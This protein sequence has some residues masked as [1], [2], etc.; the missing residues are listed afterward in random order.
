MA[1]KNKATSRPRPGEVPVYNSAAEI[2]RALEKSLR[3]LQKN[4]ISPR[5]ADAERRTIQRGSELF[6]RRMKAQIQ[7]KKNEKDR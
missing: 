4:K 6:W 2:G 7:N 1:T 3:R 5:K